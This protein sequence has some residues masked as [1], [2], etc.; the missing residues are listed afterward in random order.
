MS[1]SQTSLERLCIN[2][3]R[4]LAIDAIQ[5]ANSGHPGLPLGAAPMAHTLWYRHL[6]HDPADPA[7]PDRDRFVLSA[8]H[9]SMLLYALLHLYSYDVSQEDITSF[10]QL[11]S[12]TPGHPEFGLTPGVEATTG[13]LGQGTANAVGM[14]I[15]ERSLAHR[16]NRPGHTIVDHMTYALVS[17]GDLM[18]GVAAEAASLAGHLKLGKLVYLYDANDISLDGPTS[19]TFTEDVTRRYEAYGWQVLHVAAGDTDT[20]GISRAISEA[21]ADTERPSIIVIRTTIGYGSPNRQGTAGVHGSPLGADELRLTKEQLGLDPDASFHVP[22]DVRDA[23]LAA[24][25]R[26]TA[27]HTAWTERFAAYAEAHKDLA[28]QWQRAMAGELPADLDAILPSFAPGKNIATRQASGETLNALAERIPWLLGGDADLS[29]STK[30]ALKG[31]GSFDGVSGSGRNIHFGVREHAMGAIANGIA[32][33]GGLHPFVATFFVFSDYM[34]PAMR[35]AALSKLKVTCVFTHDSVGVGED[36]PT[37]QPVEHLLALRAMPNMTVIRPADA[38]ETAEAWKI[39]LAHRSGPVALVLSRQG[40][41]VIDRTKHG[42][43]AGVAHGAYVLLEPKEG[44]PEAILIAT[45]S[46]VHTA[47]ASA[48][49]LDA[50]GIRARVVSMPSWELF[51]A[52]DKAYRESV[53]PKEVRARVAVE[54]GVPMG[55]ERY[56]GDAGVVL[57]VEGFGASA[58]A[59]QL[60]EKYGLTAEAVMAAAKKLL[61]R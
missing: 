56:V 32:Y 48:A 61:A 29:S 14:A 9:G 49:L 7:W 5:R 43:A 57:G 44:D 39:A 8:G 52:Q 50:Q 17:D 13:P 26:G 23:L 60:I 20:E 12:R 53:L 27:A 21:K 36:G 55:W 16:F 35:V 28:E 46:E 59:N 24:R 58:P 33:H 38:T 22:D 18:E 42:P 45:G 30:T 25:A 4:T 37:H 3:I 10:R 34:R 31:A 2:T 51:D 41:P 1:D 6:K 11:E 15:A 54:A 19:L 47:L 40:L